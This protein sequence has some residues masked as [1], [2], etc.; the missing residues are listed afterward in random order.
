MECRQQTIPGG[1]KK[2]TESSSVERSRGKVDGSQLAIENKTAENNERI[3]VKIGSELTVPNSKMKLRCLAFLP[4]FKMSNDEYLTP[5]LI[6][7]IIP[8]RKW[9]LGTTKK[10]GQLVILACNLASTRSSMRKSVS[11]LLAAYQSSLEHDS[12]LS[13][14]EC[15]S[16]LARIC[17]FSLRP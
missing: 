12:I 14:N 6:I 1:C 3:Y 15:T 9:Y 11:F 17:A 2:K 13:R 7:P 5:Y 8:P 10:S 4:D 16:M